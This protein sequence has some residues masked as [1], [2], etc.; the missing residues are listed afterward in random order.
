MILMSLACL[1]KRRQVQ[2]KEDISG[3][4]LRSQCRGNELGLQDDL[5]MK[6]LVKS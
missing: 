4:S 2:E 1:G 5:L 6:V 3:F